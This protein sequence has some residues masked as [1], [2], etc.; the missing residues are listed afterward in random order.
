ML[1]IA[2]VALAKLTQIVVARLIIIL[3][4]YTDTQLSSQLQSDKTFHDAGPEP[5]DSHVQLLSFCL[6]LV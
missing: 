2:P 4:R 3:I 5:H 1:V 6:A